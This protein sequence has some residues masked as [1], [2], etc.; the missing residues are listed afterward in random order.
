MGNF[1]LYAIGSG[2]AYSVAVLAAHLHQTFCGRMAKPL[3]PLAVAQ[4]PVRKASAMLISASGRNPDVIGSFK[5]LVDL[6]PEALAVLCLRKG[7][8]LARLARRYSHVRLIEED[9]PSGK[10]G[11]VA[12]NSVIAFGMLL[13]RAYSLAFANR[14]TGAPEL[15]ATLGTTESL[16][17]CLNHC[18]RHCVVGNIS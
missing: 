4:A 15:E 10:D 16:Q 17:R 14:W 3:T 5:R 8:P 11:F 7:S 2:G 9:L 12:T 18:L 1:P 13:W 6:E